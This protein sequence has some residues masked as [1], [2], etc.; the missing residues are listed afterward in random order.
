[1]AA[2][3]RAPSRILTERKPRRFFLDREGGHASRAIA[4][5]ARHH[6]IDIRRAGAGDELFDA[7]E[8]IDVA[9]AARFRLQRRRIRACAGLGQAIARQMR[10]T[11]EPGQ[12]SRA[13]IGRTEAVDHPG[14]HVVDG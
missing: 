2:G 3:T 13:Q 11:G 8:H 5:G 4:A 6:E 1:L 9:F 14:D 10:H 12:K 7:V